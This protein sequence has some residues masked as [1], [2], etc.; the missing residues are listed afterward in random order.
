[1]KIAVIS[2]IRSNIY[3]LEAV[4]DDIKNRNVDVVL[5]LGDSFYGA[6]APKESYNLIRK[7]SF[8]NICGDKDREILEASLAQLEENNLLKYVYSDLGEEVLYFIQDL[9]F[10][11]LIGEDFYMIHG[12]YFNDMDSLFKGISNN[13]QREDSEI[14]KLTDDIK[15]NFIFC[16]N[17]NEAKVITLNTGQVVIT[18][19]NLGVSMDNEIVKDASYAILSIEENQYEVQLLKVNYDY[20]N[21][22]EKAKNSF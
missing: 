12:T 17:S 15:S 16:S 20:M 8:I 1:M 9:P 19:G 22:L 14:I 13:K 5:N 11:K 3:A 6:I 10:E 2:D 21:A 4:L 7:S 18:P